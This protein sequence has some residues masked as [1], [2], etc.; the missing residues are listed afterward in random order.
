MTRAR[1]TVLRVKHSGE[2]AEGAERKTPPAQKGPAF[3]LV[4]AA[5]GR[6]IPF[7]SLPP[8][9]PSLP[10]LLF[11]DSVSLFALLSLLA[12]PLLLA[13]LFV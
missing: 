4:G 9:L 5:Q 6:M 8:L 13:S 3:L 11:S 2:A 7:H 1:I 10:F 12:T